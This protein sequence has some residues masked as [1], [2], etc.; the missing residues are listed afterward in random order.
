MKTK[1]MQQCADNLRT[2]ERAK[3]FTII[4]DAAWLDPADWVECLATQDRNRV[5]L[6][7]LHARTPGKGAFTKLIAGIWAAGLEPVIVEPSQTLI[8]WCNR[9]NYR[10]RVVGIGQDR[11]A[12]WYPRR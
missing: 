7:L 12:V 1:L 6:V 2:I 9:H 10:R 11:H 3:G 4:A 8:D 5:R